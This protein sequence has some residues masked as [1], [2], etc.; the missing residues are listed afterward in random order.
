MGVVED[1]R[2]NKKQ[3]MGRSAA[4]LRQITLTKAKAR[5]RRDQ[6]NA[7][8]HGEIVHAGRDDDERM[9]DCV[10]EDQATIVYAAVLNRVRMHEIVGAARGAWFSPSQT[11]SLIHGMTASGQTRPIG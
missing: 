1:G 2:R 5:P 8:E 3:S 9:P 11:T 4:S 6:S 7:G 10:V